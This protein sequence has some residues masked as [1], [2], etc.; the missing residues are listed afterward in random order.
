MSEQLCMVFLR[1]KNKATT[2]IQHPI[3]GEVPS[4]QR[5]KDK[6]DRLG[7]ETPK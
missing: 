1:C 5:C 2:T 6:M 4:C 7:K 3:M